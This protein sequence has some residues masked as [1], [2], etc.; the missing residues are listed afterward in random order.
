[1]LPYDLSGDEPAVVVRCQDCQGVWFDWFDG[2]TSRLARGVVLLD[3]RITPAR[4]GACPRDRVALEMFPYLDAGPA[5]ARCPFC[6]GLW[7]GRTQLQALAD[8]HERMPEGSPEPIERASLLERL[9]YAFG[10]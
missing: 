2:E 10:R 1:M 7:A 4:V 6:L 9:W 8:F 5:V 3:G